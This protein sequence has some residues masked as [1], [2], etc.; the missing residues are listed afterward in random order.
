M[1]KGPTEGGWGWK[2]LSILFAVIILVIAGPWVAISTWAFEGYLEYSAN[3]K[4]EDFAKW[5]H[6]KVGS[7]SAKTMRPELSAEA[8]R[9][10][11]EIYHNPDDPAQ[12][13]EDTY[14]A[15][16]R[17]GEELANNRERVKSLEILQMW[18]DTYGE[19]HPFYGTVKQKQQNIQIRP[20]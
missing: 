4:G 19:L 6:L 5:L 9:Q 18:I 16:M 7:I 2:K 15:W 10:Y 13:D 8:Y 12:D 14:T 11:V 20:N 3:H 1:A 17:Y